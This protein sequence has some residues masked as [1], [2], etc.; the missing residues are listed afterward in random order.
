MTKTQ[1]TERELDLLKILWQHEGAT[2]REIYEILPE[3]KLPLAYTTV[4]SMLQ[5]ME[6]KRLVR[7]E[8]VGKAYRYYP[9]IE[10]E[11][12]FREMAGNFLDQVF[13]GAMGE[14]LARALESKRPGEKELDEMEAMIAEFRQKRKSRQRGK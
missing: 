7:H 12:T 1:P 4:L 11:R 2:V 5:T 14:Y 3:Q 6:R 10:R 9:T 13:D 8:T